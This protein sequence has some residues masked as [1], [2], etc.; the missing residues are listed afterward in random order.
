MRTSVTRSHIAQLTQEGWSYLKNVIVTSAVYHCLGE[1]RPFNI[2]ST[3][4][5]STCVHIVSDWRKPVFLVN[6]RAL[7]DIT[8]SDLPTKYGF[9]GAARQI[10]SAASPC[11]PS[12]PSTIGLRLVRSQKASEPTDIPKLPVQSVDFLY[13]HGADR[14]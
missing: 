12:S 2:D 10:G 1:F 11:G 13:S 3:G 6:S 14:P 5:G 8:S 7:L 9:V 4:Q